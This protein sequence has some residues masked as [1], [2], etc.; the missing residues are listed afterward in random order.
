MCMRRQHI[1][2]G[3]VAIVL[4]SMVAITFAMPILGVT[5]GVYWPGPRP[6][7]P[8]QDVLVYH[9]FTVFSALG[10]LQYT[11][12]LFGIVAVFSIITFACAIALFVLGAILLANIKP[13]LVYR[14]CKIAMPV[15]FFAAF[16]TALLALSFALSFS[17]PT[18]EGVITPGSIMLLFVSILGITYSIML[19]FS[20]KKEIIRG[21]TDEQV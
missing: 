21:G 14:V 5:S 7:E 19:Y 1:I 17:Y 2:L 13:D 18:A 3:V 16:V 12:A 9:R 11:N 20:G 6:S 10:I 8:V 4:S 15:I